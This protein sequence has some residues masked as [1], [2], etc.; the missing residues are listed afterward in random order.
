MELKEA[1]EA[2]QKGKTALGIELGSTNIK[3]V[4]VGKDCQTL[5]S[6]SYGWENQLED[7]IWTYDLEQVWAG[8][9]TCFTE[10]KAQVSARY[11][12][13]LQAL[14][15]IGV[16]AMMHGYLPFDAAGNLLV[17]FR[18]WRNAITGTSAKELSELFGCNI[19]QRWSVAHVYQA[20]LNGE[21]H[22]KEIAH[23]T[24]L[25]GYVHEQLTGEAIL[26]VGDAS[27]MFPLDGAGRYDKEKILQF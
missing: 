11:Q 21:A 15:S 3:A 8:I 18:T 23:L 25:A 7:G 13:P 17:P 6:A 9:Q 12:A 1:T 10:T 16:S 4:L 5:A 14:G 26:G 19:P 20:V 27:G 2:I 24:T 22:V